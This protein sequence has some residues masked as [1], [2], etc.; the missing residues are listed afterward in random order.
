MTLLL[1]Q[2][3]D[4][5]ERA[6]FAPKLCVPTLGR[7]VNDSPLETIIGLVLCKRHLKELRPRDF[8]VI[9]PGEPNALR[10]LFEMQSQ[11]YRQA[12][13]DFFRAFFEPVDIHGSQ[14]QTFMRMSGEMPPKPPKAAHEAPEKIQ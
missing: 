12:P 1:C 13:P 2:K 8:L 14:Y 6:K 10:K 3:V 4:C 11:S 5:P 7:S 9:K